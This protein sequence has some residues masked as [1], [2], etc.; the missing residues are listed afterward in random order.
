MAKICHFREVS[1]DL[2]IFMVC[3]CVLYCKCHTVG[4]V[5]IKDVNDGSVYTDSP[6]WHISSSYLMCKF[7]NVGNALTYLMY[8]TM[9]LSTE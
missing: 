9:Y 3:V 5:Y 6:S 2:L 1:C 4:A 7:C 8:L